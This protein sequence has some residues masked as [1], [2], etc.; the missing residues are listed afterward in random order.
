M[1]KGK[2]AA[3]LLPA[4]QVVIKSTGTA[5][6]RLKPKGHKHQSKYLFLLYIINHIYLPSLSIWSAPENKVTPT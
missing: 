4:A 5:H 2:S 1:T 3:N 6:D